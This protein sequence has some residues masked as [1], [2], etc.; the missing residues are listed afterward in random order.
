MIHRKQIKKITIKHLRRKGH[1][2]RPAE[3]RGKFNDGRKI[4]K[5]R[6]KEVYKHEKLGH[7]EGDTVESKRID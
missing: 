7:W 2:K 3:T 1:F 5:K 4:I 6:L